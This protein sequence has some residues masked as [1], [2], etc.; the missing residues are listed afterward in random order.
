MPRMIDLVRASVLPAATV[1]SMA[2]GAIALPPREV[3]EILVYLANHNPE[4]KEDARK[5]LSGWNENQIKTIVA[6]PKASKEV[7]DYFRASAQPAPKPTVTEPV[8]KPQS[9]EQIKP[10]ERAKEEPPKEIAAATQAVAPKAYGEI[11]ITE[12][13]LPGEESDGQAVEDNSEEFAVETASVPDAEDSDAV[14]AAY[15]KE[16]EQELQLEGEKPFQPLGGV[17]EF[18]EEAEEE[19]A[20]KTMAAAAGVGTGAAVSSIQTAQKRKPQ[21]QGKAGEEE[22]GSVLQKISK[23]DIKGRIQLALKGTKEE[24]SI[25]IRD[26]AKLVCLAVLESPKITDGEVE[27]FASQKNVLEAVLRQIP[28]KRRFMKNYIIVRNLVGNP[29]TPLD[30]ALGLMKNLLVNDLKNLSANKDVSDTIRKL[31]LKMYKQKLSPGKG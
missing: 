29:R 27:K 21:G 20:E 15:M 8:I 13:D 4:V 19:P 25:L 17:F 18:E 23:L 12:A 22:R 7:L 11:E 16:H 10:A 2:R 24:R 28:M 30:V 14:F 9:A 3:I 31:A 6:D 1:R 26:A 5:T